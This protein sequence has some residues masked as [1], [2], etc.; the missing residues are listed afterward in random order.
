MTDIPIILLAFI[1]AIALVPPLI[2]YVFRTSFPPSFIMWLGGIIWL[3]IFL[4]TDNISLGNINTEQTYNNATNTLENGYTCDCY[5]IRD[6]V[7]F[8]PSL[9][10]ILFM[11]LAL[12]YIM[13]GVLAEKML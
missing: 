6:S 4:T 2:A 3:M 8:E 5:A 7:T 10:G 13:I 11:M 12:V 9:Y 1:S